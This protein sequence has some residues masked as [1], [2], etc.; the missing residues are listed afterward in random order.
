MNSSKQ[1]LKGLGDPYLD[2]RGDFFALVGVHRKLDLL[3]QW[4]DYSGM[5]L[6]DICDGRDVWPNIRIAKAFIVDRDD[7]DTWD[8]GTRDDMEDDED[9]LFEWDLFMKVDAKGPHT[10]TVYMESWPEEGQ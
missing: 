6:F 3:R 1:I 5:P 9:W 7:P 8:D 10:V 2:D 4:M